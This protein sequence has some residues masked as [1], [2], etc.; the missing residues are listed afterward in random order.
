[1]DYGL[2][3]IKKVWLGISSMFILDF[4]LRIIICIVLFSNL[5]VYVILI[6]VFYNNKKNID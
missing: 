2:I 3:N 5:E 1:M 4:V 6:V